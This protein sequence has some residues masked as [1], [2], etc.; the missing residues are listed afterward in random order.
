MDALF[1]HQMNNYSLGYNGGYK[2]QDTK[3]KTGDT[4]RVISGVLKGYMFVVVDRPKNRTGNQQVNIWTRKIHDGDQACNEEHIGYL[5]SSVEYEIVYTCDIR[6]LRTGQQFV[7]KGKTYVRLPTMNLRCE[8]WGFVVNVI[9]VEETE[10]ERVPPKFIAEH[11]HE[12]T[13]VEK[14]LI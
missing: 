6:S 12:D 10:D 2:V 1:L 4:I 8:P 14:K 13:I 7:Y 5:T 11:F 3:A 9:R